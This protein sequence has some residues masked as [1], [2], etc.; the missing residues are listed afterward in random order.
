VCQGD[1]CGQASQPREE[2]DGGVIV[3][4]TAFVVVAH[5]KVE[6]QSIKLRTVGASQPTKL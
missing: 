6:N 3:S 1:G 4:A 2:R 5:N